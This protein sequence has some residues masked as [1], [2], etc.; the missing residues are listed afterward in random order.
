MGSS[1]R[2]FNRQRTIHQILGGDLVADVMLWRQKNL[3]VGILVVILAA[4]VV[5]E[6][7]GYTLLSLTSSVFFAP[8]YHSFSLGKISSYFKQAMHFSTILHSY[9]NLFLSWIR[10]CSI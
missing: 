9:S 3:T 5:F 7:S 2:L 1:D 6:R 4:W 8:V 10:I